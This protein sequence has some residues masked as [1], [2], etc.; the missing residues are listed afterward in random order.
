MIRI[1]WGIRKID[2]NEGGRYVEKPG[3]EA[4]ESVFQRVK[5]GTPADRLRKGL[6]G[7]Q[8][9]AQR[10]AARIKTPLS[11][12]KSDSES[13]QGDRR[14]AGASIA[15]FRAAFTLSATFSGSQEDHRDSCFAMK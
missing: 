15:Y 11:R 9:V 2:S 7:S 6:S 12:D 13:K 3:V 14:I 5:A 1:Q 4:S 8:A 10:E